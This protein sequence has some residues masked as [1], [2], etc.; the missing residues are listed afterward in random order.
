MQQ[1]AAVERQESVSRTYGDEE[2]LLD[3]ASMGAEFKELAKCAKAG[4]LHGRRTDESSR[5]KIYH[6]KAYTMAYTAFA[7]AASRGYR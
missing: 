5:L 3:N 2:L 7:A 1:P 6:H 4:F